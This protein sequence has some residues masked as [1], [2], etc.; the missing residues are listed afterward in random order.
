M[1]TAIKAA[2]YPTNG[3]MTTTVYAGSNLVQDICTELERLDTTPERI[4]LYARFQLLVFQSAE[5]LEIIIPENDPDE[6]SGAYLNLVI[7]AHTPGATLGLWSKALIVY[8]ERH[9]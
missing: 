6:E 2:F 5:V 9:N 1:I 3:A 8:C 7:E 4:G